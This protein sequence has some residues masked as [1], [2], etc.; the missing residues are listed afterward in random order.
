MSTQNGQPAR[1]AALKYAIA[2]I[3]SDSRPFIMGSIINVLAQKTRGTRAEINCGS[4]FLP[5]IFLVRLNTRRIIN[6]TLPASAPWILADTLSS[7][8]ICFANCSMAASAR[9]PPI[10]DLVHSGTE[11]YKAA[12]RRQSGF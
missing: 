1:A 4:I 5:N 12:A 3:R 8:V 9:L 6:E 11:E 7:E 10:H 2:R